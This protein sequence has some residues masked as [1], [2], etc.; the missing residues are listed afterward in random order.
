MCNKIELT[1]EEIIGELRKKIL[2]EGNKKKEVPLTP[3]QYDFILRQMQCEK[4]SLQ[5]DNNNLPI[6]RSNII[7]KKKRVP[8]AWWG[9]SLKLYQMIKRGLCNGQAY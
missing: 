6:Y 9:W 1:D 8:R 2:E 4:T 5:S 7:K 3:Q